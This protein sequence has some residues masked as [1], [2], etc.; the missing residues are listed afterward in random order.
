MIKEELMYENLEDNSDNEFVNEDTFINDD[1]MEQNQNLD[2]N[3][4]NIESQKPV[5]VRNPVLQSLIKDQHQNKQ[6]QPDFKPN[7]N[8][9]SFSD[10]ENDEDNISVNGD[11]GEILKIMVIKNRRGN[12]ALIDSENFVYHL[13]S[14]NE[15]ND[16]SY[17][18]CA[19]R[20]RQGCKVRIQIQILY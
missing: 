7:L 3:S 17:W 11:S 5:I 4:A 8:M 9:M 20:R 15:Y 10:N 16:M 2:I 6:F 14:F 1:I 18:Q 19:Q 12:D 13:C